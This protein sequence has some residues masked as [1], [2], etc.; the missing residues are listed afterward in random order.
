MATGLNGKKTADNK[1]VTRFMMEWPLYFSNIKGSDGTNVWDVVAPRPI[2]GKTMGQGITVVHPDTGYTEHPELLAGGRIDTARSRNFLDDSKNSIDPLIE[3]TSLA[4]VFPS[5][6]LPNRFPSHGTAT[7]SFL[8]SGAGYP[9]DPANNQPPASYTV[10]QDSYV[11]VVAPGARLIPCLVT[12][13]VMLAGDSVRALTDAIY[14]AIDLSVR[15]LSVGVMS[16]SLGCLLSPTT[17]TSVGRKVFQGNLAEAVRSARRNGVIICAAAGQLFENAG[18]PLPPT[19]PG[20]DENCICVAACDHEHKML[21]TGFYSSDVDI[22]APG[23]NVWHARAKLG[24]GGARSYSIDG[25]GV[26]SSYATAFVAGACA[27]W[28]AHYDRT[29]LIIDYGA[30]LIFDLFRWA[31]SHSSD[32]RGGTWNTALHGAGVLDVR[33]LLELQLISKQELIDWVNSQ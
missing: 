15:D 32:T 10:P 3:P 18:K 14:Y 28:Q 4:P 1:P 26:G 9:D 11:T 33:K 22:T 27:L 8:V 24:S 7:G 2:T 20:N 12:D 21:N 6:N 30:D 29:Q 13:S 5:A 16:I 17:S 31:L 25:E 19:Y 23:V